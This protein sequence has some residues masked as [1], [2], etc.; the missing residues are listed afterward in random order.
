MPMPTPPPGTGSGSGFGSGPDSA[1]PGHGRVRAASGFLYPPGRPPD[2]TTLV[3]CV[4]RDGT[5]RQDPVVGRAAV[6]DLVTEVGV[7][8]PEDSLVNCLLEALRVAD[9]IDDRGDEAVVAVVTGAGDPVAIDRGIAE[10]ID[11]LVDDY[12]PDAA[13][14][15]VDSAE[16]ERAIPIIE[17][18]VR[19]DAVDRVVVRQARDIES[20]YYL[21][22]QFV[23]DEELRATVLVP[24]GAALLALPVLLTVTGSAAVTAAVVTAVVGTVFLY[25]G[26][27]IDDLFAGLPGAVREAFYAGQVSLVTYVVG[28]GLAIVGIFAGAIAVS[29][30]RAGPAGTV[31][32]MTLRFAFEGAPW[33]ALAALAASTGRLFDELLTAGTVRASFLNLP[34]GVVAI[35]FVVRG[36]AA[37]FLENAAVVGPLVVAPISV[38]PVSVDGLVLAGPTRLAAHVLTGI[39]V[40]LAGVWFASYVGGLTVDDPGIRGQ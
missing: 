15:V 38:G 14:V 30:M 24:L 36:F 2:V 25:K 27:G 31:P 3:L 40:S 33:F 19:V 1:E 20:T 21:L 12:D 18:R 11:R 37:F 23:A 16:D 8:D 28:F 34:F 32:L 7:A 6:A 26:L 13:V 17:S 4:D 5:D 22:K 10:R 9:G 35:G 29:G 39:L